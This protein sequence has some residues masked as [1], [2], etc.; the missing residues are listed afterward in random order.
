[1]DLGKSLRLPW[2][3][4]AGRLIIRER[5]T[6]KMVYT[7]GLTMWMLMLQRLGGGKKFTRK[8]PLI[9]VDKAL[10]SRR[11]DQLG[12]TLGQQFLGRLLADSARRNWFIGDLGSDP[13]PTIGAEHYGVQ[14]QRVSFDPCP[15]AHRRQ[16]AP[17]QRR[18]HAAFRGDCC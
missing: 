12:G 2:L 16:A 3:T 13:L 6:S 4:P 5:P 1:M 15:S 7:H 14:N 9:S 17:Q 18:Q 8:H 11:R 10:T